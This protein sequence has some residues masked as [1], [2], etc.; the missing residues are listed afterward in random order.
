MYIMFEILPKQL[1]ELSYKMPKPLYIVGGAV[2]N[3][4]IDGS[5]STDIDLAG[6]IPVD[7]F[8]C[9]LKE[10]GITKTAEYPKT[11][12]VKFSDGTYNYEYTAFRRDKYVN[13]EHLPYSTEF[14]EDMMEDALN[15]IANLYSA[16]IKKYLSNGAKKPEK[17]LYRGTKIK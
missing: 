2:R 15:N 6:A 11:C 12:T 8:L 17:P 14:T 1:I 10:F 5:L 13:G 4:L 7:K 9:V 3:Y 16:I